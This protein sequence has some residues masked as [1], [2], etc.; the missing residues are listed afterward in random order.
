MPQN[1]RPCALALALSNPQLSPLA[2]HSDH[3]LVPER[4]VPP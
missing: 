1:V 3:A 2:V 4:T